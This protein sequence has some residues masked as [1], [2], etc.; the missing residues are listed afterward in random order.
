M[1][2]EPVAAPI[3]GFRRWGCRRGSLY[4][5]IFVAGHFVPN[6]ALGL[7]A[8]RARPTPWPTGADRPA[9]CFRLRGHDAPD[10]ECTCGFSAYYALPEAPELP[11]PEAVWG[12]IVAWGRIVECETG[13]RAQYARPIALLDVP[14]AVDARRARRLAGAAEAYAVPLLARDELVAYAAWHG[15]LVEG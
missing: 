1:S 4:S 10:R 9:K 5:G 11:A 15:E 14:S 6:P 8:P 13:F 2:A 3:A 7:V 12:A